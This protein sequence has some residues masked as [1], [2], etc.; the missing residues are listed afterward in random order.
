MNCVHTDSVVMAVLDDRKV[1]STEQ[2]D[3]DL[4]GTVEVAT[5]SPQLV[6]AIQ[7]YQRKG[8]VFVA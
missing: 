7:Q 3:T 8:K 4:I 6:K 2:S 1:R 5:N